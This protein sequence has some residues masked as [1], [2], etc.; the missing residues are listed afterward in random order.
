MAKLKMLEFVY[1]CIKKYIPDD[2]FEFIEMD[3]DSLYLSLCSNFLDELV[4]PELRKEFFETYDYFFPSLACEQHKK[5]FVKTR[6]RNLEWKPANCC[7]A[8][9]LSDKCT[10]IYS[11]WSSLDIKCGSCSENLHL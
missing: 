10:P 3:T 2:C 1:D 5:E 6:V 4:A 11:S 7:K 8:G 9:E